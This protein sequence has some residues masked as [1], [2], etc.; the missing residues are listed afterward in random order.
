MVVAFT[1]WAAVTVYEGKHHRHGTLNPIIHKALV[2]AKIPSQLEPAGLFRSGGNHPDGMTFVPYSL[3]ASCLSGMPSVL[4]PVRVS[5]YIEARQHKQQGKSQQLQRTG[6]EGPQ[7][8]WPGLPVYA[9]CNRDFWPFRPQSQTYI[10]EL[11]SR[12]CQ[13]TGEEMATSY[14]MQHLSMAIQRGDVAAVLGSLGHACNND[15][16]FQPLFIFLLHLSSSTDCL[17]LLYCEFNWN[18]I[19]LQRKCLHTN[20][21]NTEL[22]K[23]QHSVGGCRVPSTHQWQWV[24]W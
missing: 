23:L 16:H 22:S 15:W 4:T 20:S 11:G 3:V 9:G 7:I 10:K 19:I 5:R 14:L 17:V 6:L 21:F 18:W 13:E 2:S 8:P 1:V 24:L 12:I